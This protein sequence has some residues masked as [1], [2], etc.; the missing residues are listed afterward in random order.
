MREKVTEMPC[1]D[2]DC[3]ATAEVRADKR[4]KLYVICPECG[5]FTYNTLRG[6]ERL[7]AKLAAL[8]AAQRP[9]AEQVGGVTFGAPEPEPLPVQEPEPKADGEGQ[10]Y[11]RWDRWLI[12][13]GIA[14][15]VGSWWW[16]RQAA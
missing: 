16:K 6:Q 5:R 3:E 4:G 9:P 7:K 2:P 13:A 8:E 12:L 1:P 10:E 14:I 11:R 15:G